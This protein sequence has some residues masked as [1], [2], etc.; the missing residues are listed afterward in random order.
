MDLRKPFWTEGSMI[1]LDVAKFRIL[2]A[3]IE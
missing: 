3:R 2:L 1:L